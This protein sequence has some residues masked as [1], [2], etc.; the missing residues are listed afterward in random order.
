MAFLRMKWF[1]ITR[2]ELHSFKSNMRNCWLLYIGKW[3]SS[4]GKTK[5]RHREKKKQN[6]FL[7]I[8]FT[9]KKCINNCSKSCNLRPF[10][11]VF[12]TLWK[13]SSFSRSILI[14]TF[15]FHCRTAISTGHAGLPNSIVIELWLIA[16]ALLRRVLLGGPD[17]SCLC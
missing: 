10:L 15:F 16:Y 12:Q 14:W 13:M 6:I 3:S 2:T 7:T 9:N 11:K 8:A 17:I 5:V 4:N 1:P